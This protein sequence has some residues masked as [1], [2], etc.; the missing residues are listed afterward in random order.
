MQR[1]RFA[2]VEGAPLRG[3]PDALSKPV[4]LLTDGW[5]DQPELGALANTAIA[6]GLISLSELSYSTD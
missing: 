3:E 4:T 1:E 2:M 6:R 5:L